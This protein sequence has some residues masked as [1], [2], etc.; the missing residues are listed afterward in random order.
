MS[1]KRRSFSY[2]FNQLIFN[3]HCCLSYHLFCCTQSCWELHLTLKHTDF[4]FGC[5]QIWSAYAYNPEKQLYRVD[6][7]EFR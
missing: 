6:V 3:V 7:E 5:L 1:S 4:P 2:F